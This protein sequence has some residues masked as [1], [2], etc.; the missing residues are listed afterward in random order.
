[1]DLKITSTISV[2]TLEEGKAKS[3]RKD[4]ERKKKH[5]L[6]NPAGGFMSDGPL[7]V[8]TAGIPSA[9]AYPEVFPYY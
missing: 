3:E 7:G 6:V 9:L 4:K 2:L 5:V 8:R 1:M